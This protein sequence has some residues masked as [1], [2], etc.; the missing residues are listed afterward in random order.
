MSDEMRLI[1][2]ETRL[3][4]Q[5]QAMGELSDV[6]HRQQ[7]ELEALRHALNQAHADLQNLREH[8]S[9][10]SLPEPPPPHY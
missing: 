1:E 7:R 5:E 4:F 3:A 2:I 10:G 9:S 8:A 6:I